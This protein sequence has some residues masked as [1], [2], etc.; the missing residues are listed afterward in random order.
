MF[1]GLL[2]QCGRQ[3]GCGFGQRLRCQAGFTAGCCPGVPH[4]HGAHARGRGVVVHDVHRVADQCLGQLAGSADRR[5]GENEGGIRSVQR[6]H[7]SKAPQHV[8]AVTPEHAPKQVQ[9]V[10]DHVAQVAKEA[11][12][13]T[14]MGQQPMVQHLGIGQYHPGRVAGPGSFLG[15]G[16]PIHRGGEQLGDPQA[17]ERPQLVLGKCLGGVDEQGRGA[18]AGRRDRLGDRDLKAPGLARGG[19]GGDHGVATGTDQVD[20]CGLVRPQREVDQARESVRQGC[21]QGRVPARACGHRQHTG[22]PGVAVQVGQRRGERGA[23]VDGC[24]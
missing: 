3:G 21:R 1:G 15:S 6:G 13:S 10:H 20:R 11:G 5:R 18:T 12:P 24:G 9:L 8:G 17:A 14:V 22:Q 23:R 2:D 4:H 19:A 16:I 7:P